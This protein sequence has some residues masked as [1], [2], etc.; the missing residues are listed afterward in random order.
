MSLTICLS[1]IAV[2]FGFSDLLWSI[3]LVHLYFDYISSRRQDKE[4]TERYNTLFPED[5]EK[6]EQM[7][8]DS[9]NEEKNAYFKEMERQRKEILAFE[10]SCL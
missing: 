3:I 6:I 7:R 2:Y 10:K 4:C 5:K 9:K 1:C 8:I